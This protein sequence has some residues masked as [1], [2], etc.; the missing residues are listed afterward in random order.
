MP[1]P[2]SYARHDPS[3]T[4]LITFYISAE[5]YAET[6]ITKIDYPS[7]VNF[8]NMNWYWILIITLMFIWNRYISFHKSDID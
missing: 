7:V 8:K 3:Q 2:H 6:Q 1:T 5:G 4:S